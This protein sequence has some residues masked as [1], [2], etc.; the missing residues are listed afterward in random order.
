M[1]FQGTSMVIKLVDYDG[2]R[3]FIQVHKQREKFGDLAS[4][5]P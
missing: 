2:L 3:V 5:L 1:Q 4:L